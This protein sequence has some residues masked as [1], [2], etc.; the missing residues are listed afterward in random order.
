MVFCFHGLTSKE[1]DE[2]FM[3]VIHIIYL[4]RDDY[5]KTRIIQGDK[6]CYEGECFGMSD[7]LKNAQIKHW[8]VD[9]DILVLEIRNYKHS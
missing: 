7:A 8:S 9:N 5:Q 6:V 2:I 1:R 3:N 4:V